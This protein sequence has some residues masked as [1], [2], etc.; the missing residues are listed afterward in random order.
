MISNLARRNQIESSALLVTCQLGMDMIGPLSETPRG[1]KYIVTL[2]DTFP[3]GQKQHHSHQSMLKVLPNSVSLSH[4]FGVCSPLCFHR[5]AQCLSVVD[6]I[7]K[8]CVDLVICT[9]LLARMPA[10]DLILCSMSSFYPPLLY[11]CSCTDNIC[12]EKTA[13]GGNCLL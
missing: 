7:L 11:T 9:D 10:D 8:V 1:N 13:L 12:A 6:F 2:T 3:S 5:L 4:T